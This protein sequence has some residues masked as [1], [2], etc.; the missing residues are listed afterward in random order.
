MNNRSGAQSNGRP[1][2]FA[3]LIGGSALAVYCLTLSRSVSFIDSGELAAVAYTLGIA[4]PTGYP[5]FTLI[6][7]LIAHLPLPVEEIIKLNLM[8][9]VLCVAGVVVFFFFLRRFLTVVFLR[10]GAGQEGRSGLLLDAASAGGA[11]TLA[12]SETYWAQAQSVEVYSLHVL[13]LSLILFTAAHAAFG[14]EN[15]RESYWLLFALL[16]GLSF[17]NHMTTILLAPGMLALYFMSQG[18]TRKAWGRLGTMAIPFALALSLYCYLPIRSSMGPSLDWGHPTSLE[19]LLWH[20]SG[21]QYRVWI[22]SSTEVAGR[23]LN[24]FLRNLPAEFAYIGL[25]LAIWGLVRLFLLHK[26]LAL[27]T[28]LLF[29]SCVLYSINYDIHDIDSYFL[30]AYVCVAIWSSI[31][32]YE[33]GRI[34]WPVA[35][36]RHVV[37][38]VLVL[39]GLLSLWFHYSVNNEAGNYLVEDYTTNM[40]H[41]VDSNA[42]VLSYQW[43]YW[44]SAS[45][46]YQQV[47]RYRRDVTVVDK[48]LLRR[49]WYL[50]ELSRNAP[51]LIRNS[52]P[53]VEAFRKELYKFEH[54]LPYNPSVIQARFVEMVSSFIRESMKRGPV[55]VTPE[56]EPEFTPSLQRVPSGLA[57]RLY[58]DT[59]FHPP[60]EITYHFRPFSAKSDPVQTIHRLYASAFKARGTYY[61]YEGGDNARAVK[62]FRNALEFNPSDPES[63]RWLSALT[64]VR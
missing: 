61:Y 35:R 11:F 21:K 33:A 26:R 14:E 39:P 4:H 42:V 15:R 48:E 5:L 62:A 2:I 53:A 43:D 57:L 17:T 9:A 63:A 8:A 22:F 24:Y 29:V 59:L 6:G 37:A 12:F 27:A 54:E 19:R 28:S 20:L 1:L 10:R 25:A 16:V 40:F 55:Y 32:L 23:Q 56:I 38:V 50:D 30:L 34:L 36:S 13:F 58:A 3:F 18:N 51:F 46:Y 60:P 44:V 7:W 31:G 41:S 47:R 52:L 45:L 49:S 64:R